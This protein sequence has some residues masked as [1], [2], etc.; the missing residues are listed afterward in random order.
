MCLFKFTCIRTNLS[1]QLY[2]SLD[3]FRLANKLAF[4]SSVLKD[5]QHLPK[6]DIFALGL[7]IALAA[8][9]ESLPSNG[10]EWHDIRQGN[11]PDIPQELSEEFYN[12]LKVISLMK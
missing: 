1:Y 5:Y 10:D 7:T 8:G 2:F 3:S 12:L 11:L 6:G 9:A 4:L